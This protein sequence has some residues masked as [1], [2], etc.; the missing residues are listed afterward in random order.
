MPLVFACGYSAVYGGRPPEAL[1]SVVPSVQSTPETDA[2]AAVLAGVRKELS[3]EGALKAGTSYPRL[4]I[5]VLRVDEEPLGIA[6]ALSDGHSV[7]LARG[8]RIAVTA[9]GWVVE[10]EGA[11]PATDTGDLRR[12]ASSASEAAPV[13]DLQARVMAIRAAGNEVGIALARRALGEATAGTEP[14]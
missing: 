7:A 2:V 8:M 13:V 4:V 9:R 12:S 6:E 14:L 11:D 10:R 5:E 3:K 1:L